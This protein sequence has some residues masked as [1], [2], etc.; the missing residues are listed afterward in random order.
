MS[1]S[2]RL[3]FVYVI[4]KEMLKPESPTY[5]SFSKE[6]FEKQSTPTTFKIRHLCKKP[7]IQLISL[8]CSSYGLKTSQVILLLSSL[9]KPNSTGLSHQRE[10]A[11][12]TSSGVRR[13]V[14]QLFLFPQSKRVEYLFSWERIFK[15]IAFF[16]SWKVIPVVFLHK[17]NA[18]FNQTTQETKWKWQ[19][20]Q[21]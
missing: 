7:T 1:S 16:R 18:W 21:G 15:S 12:L 20:G 19:K 5:K 4:Q 9:L 11:V 13:L 14:L 10:L 6:S 2:K 8:S 3:L 17:C